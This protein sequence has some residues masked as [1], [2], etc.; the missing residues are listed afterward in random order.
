MRGACRRAAAASRRPQKPR[1]A[2][3]GGW[4]PY[5]CLSGPIAPTR[6]A[7]AVLGFPRGV[8]MPPFGSRRATRPPPPAEPEPQAVTLTAEERLAEAG[9][10]LH[11]WSEELARLSAE[12]EMHGVRRAEL[13]ASET[14]P[15][16][17]IVAVEE[18]AKLT[19]L[20]LE[21][22]EQRQ[23]ALLET[24]HECRIAVH[25]ERWQRMQPELAAAQDALAEAIETF[26]QTQ[27][28]AL[29]LHHAA[30]AR[31]YSAQLGTE[32][33]RPPPLEAFN[34]YS[35]R[36]YLRTIAQRRQAQQ[37]D[38]QAP[39]VWVEL[40]ADAPLGQRFTPRRVDPREVERISPL[41]E[42]RRVHVLHGPVRT[43]N[44]NV[45]HARLHPGETPILPARAA[46]ALVASGVA[47]YLEVAATAAA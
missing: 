39:E 7:S 40:P 19:R 15:I 30:H 44:L 21:R 34:D 31:G 10:A 27:A 12:L 38:A 28:H 47:E 26:Y 33:V 43:A 36:G 1:S 9:R 24:L 29:K 32:F 35:F 17:E 13:L 2:F 23:A 11:S 22:H 20:E 42:P 3:L 6:P 16:A 46:F 45:G 18:Q 14:A 5:R 25:A 37:P 4:W 8:N 41:A